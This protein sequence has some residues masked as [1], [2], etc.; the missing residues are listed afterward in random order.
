MLRLV[1]ICV[2]LG[3][4]IGVAQPDLPPL[5]LEAAANPLL[6][7]D[8]LRGGTIVET[9]DRYLLLALAGESLSITMAR[10][11][12]DLIPLL[13][14]QTLDGDALAEVFPQDLS[15]RV[16]ELNYEVI[17]TAWY[18]VIAGRDIVSAP[19][20]SGTYLIEMTGATNQLYDLLTIDAPPEIA[21]APV[22][23]GG[24]LAGR[25]QDALH[26]L[27]PLL[28]GDRIILTEQQ[29]ANVELR[30][31]EGDLLSPIDYV[32]EAGEWVQMIISPGDDASYA[33]TV[34]IA[35][36]DTAVELSLDQ[37]ITATPSPT[38]TP[39]HT[40]THT[41]TFTASFTPSR[42][43]TFT[44]TSTPTMTHT[45]SNTPT[46]TL[47]PSH[48]FTPTLTYTPS[49][50]S[51]PTLTHTPSDTPTLTY[52][53]SRT[54]SLTPSNT[55][56]PT[57]T[58]TPSRTP[59][60]QPIS[61]PGL[62]PSRLAVGMTGRVTPGA[63][64]NLRSGPSRFADRLAQI[65]GGNAFIVVGGPVCDQYTW[66]QVEYNGIIGWTVEGSAREYYVD[67]VLD[68]FGRNPQQ[69]Y[70][71]YPRQCNQSL[72]TRLT[73]NMRI[74]TVQQVRLRDTPTSVTG[75]AL[76]VGTD[77]LTLDV[78][79]CAFLEGDPGKA[80][81]L[82]WHVR[83]LEGSLAGQQGWISESSLDGYNADID[84]TP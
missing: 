84:L 78:P 62:L 67:P 13:M 47:T 32:S 22:F 1:L 41:P 33:L 43:P 10:T 81:L 79:I 60:S 15:G 61:C 48:T 8:A 14:L 54:P 42:T 70:G 55:L 12:G 77:L 17:E 9:E 64:N 57:R 36:S 71:D 66:L 31:V 56:R 40:Y 11:S 53:P 16:A 21:D 20:S 26:Y 28:R 63:P 46:F 69:D 4:M 35:H 24:A 45:P 50:T 82:W 39:T 7:P 30:S 29:N 51:T 2:L 44:R 18:V 25:G 65:P 72:V 80:E 52:T 58:P 73:P 19:T 76:A 59:S 27:V 68:A 34:S 74:L 38:L 5:P 37:L 83:V 6:F 3:V 75:I 49:R 23:L